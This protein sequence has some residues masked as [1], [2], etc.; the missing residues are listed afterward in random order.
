[1]KTNISLDL[2][3]N[4]RKHLRRH[5]IKKSEILN[6]ASDDL[7][8]ILHVP[9][10]R[11]GEIR[12]LAD[13]QRIPSVGIE[14]AR[15]LVFLGFH[16]VEELK[17][18]RGADLTDY[19]EKKK[20]YKTDPCV[21]DQFRLVVDFASNRDHSKRWWNFTNERKKYRN[22]FGYP[23]DRP[24]TSWTEVYYPKERM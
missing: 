11:A 24:E 9:E 2:S 14:F 19:Y 3:E 6:Y 17:G 1:M 13:F 22:R 16:T 4:E 5:K 20:G 21:E 7:A 15:D 8:A 18:K 10:S 23:K 12:A